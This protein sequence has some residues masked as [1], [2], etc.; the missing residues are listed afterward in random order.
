M[1]V[2]S[3]ISTVICNISSLLHI[4]N[5]LLLSSVRLEL[6]LSNL[7]PNKTSVLLL[8]ECRKLCCNRVFS[9]GSEVTFSSVTDQNTYSLL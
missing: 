4:N 9:Q 8:F 1:S 6:I 5:M 2:L 3:V 7:I